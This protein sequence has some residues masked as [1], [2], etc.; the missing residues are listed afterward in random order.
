MLFAVCAVATFLGAARDLPF[1]TSAT[2]GTAGALTKADSMLQHHQGV[3]AHPQRGQ[4]TDRHNQPM[5]GSVNA[6]VARA[7][8][9]GCEMHMA[10]RTEA[11]EAPTYEPTAVAG[12]AANRVEEAPTNEPTAVAGIAANR[13]EDADDK[14]PA[15]MDG[16][17]A[18][19][20]TCACNATSSAAADTDIGSRFHGSPQHMFF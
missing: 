11:S 17:A 1:P 16:T 20:A 14:G 5:R 6:R 19:L 9:N 12:I 10:W 4:Q 18:N 8:E 2:G 13:A 3:V 7:E 15:E